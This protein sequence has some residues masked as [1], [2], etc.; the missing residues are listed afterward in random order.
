MIQ[1]TLERVRAAPDP[2]P[3]ES[4]LEHMVTS[5]RSVRFGIPGAVLAVSGPDGVATTVTLGTDAN[6]APIAADS[7]FPLNSASKLGT[8]L[9]ILRLVDE[10]RIELDAPLG[11][12]LPEARA[13]RTPDVTIRALLTHTSGLTLEPPH[14]L[15]DPPGS[16][17]YKEG[18]RWPGELAQA[19]LAAEP[20]QP[21]GSGVRY[22]NIGFGLLGLMAERI[23]GAPFAELM[24]AKVLKPLNIQASFGRVPDRA[25]MA[26]GVWDMPSPYLGTALEPFNCPTWYQLGTPWTSLTVTVSGALTLVRAYLDGGGLLR[27]ETA[28]MARSDQTHGLAGGFPTKEPFIGRYRS[29]SIV[30][31]PCAWGLG[32]EVQGGKKPHWGPARL[33]KSF[34]QIGSSGSLAWCDPDSGV[35]WALLGPRSTDCGWLVF[36]G[37]RVASAALASVGVVQQP[38]Q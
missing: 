29:K 15:S 6:G 32:V 14:D 28:Q 20:A 8:T 27:P 38:A 13:A 35:A 18:I 30:W 33:P 2:A 23:T 31:D 36:H 37:S 17:V 1:G 22:S 24:Q 21:P 5:D 12:Y 3:L 7:L 16:L 19:C 10:Q 26:V 25:P 4:V 34:G 9:L 11:A